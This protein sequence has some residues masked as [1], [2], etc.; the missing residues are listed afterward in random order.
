MTPRAL[1]GVEAKCGGLEGG[2]C[3]SAGGRERESVCD[4]VWSQSFGEA[5][6]GRACF[7][8]CFGRLW[9]ACNFSVSSDECCWSSRCFLKSRRSNETGVS[10]GCFWIPSVLFFLFVWPRRMNCC[11]PRRAG[12]RSGSYSRA[13]KV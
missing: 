10:G 4:V 5:V 13:R 6:I 1:E 2:A 7:L 3:R 12:Y 8:G 9:L 11:A